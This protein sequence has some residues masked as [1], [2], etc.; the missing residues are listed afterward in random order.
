MEVSLWRKIVR[1]FDLF[2]NRVRGRLSHFPILYAFIGGAGA[3]IFWRGI[4]HTMD[5]LMLLLSSAQ[6]GDASVDLDGLLWWD[7]PLSVFIGAVLLLATG[8]FVSNFIGN[9][10]IITGLRGEKKVAEKT[11]VEVR[12]EAGSLAEIKEDVLRV[13]KILDREY[14][15]HH[16]H[17]HHRHEVS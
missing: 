7:G 6:L 11:E 10:I 5:Y 15:E 16:H 4:W 17:G 12:T 13:G 14:S 1:L 3:V 8:V 2:E 9:E